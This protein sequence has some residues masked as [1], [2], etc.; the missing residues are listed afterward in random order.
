MPTTRSSSCTRSQN[1]S[2]SRSANDLRPFHVGTGATRMRKILAPRSWTY[3]SS[4]SGAV[5]AGGEADDRR[6]VDARRSRRRSSARASTRS[7]R[8]SPRT[9][10]SGSSARRSSSTLA[11]V[12]HSSVR[13]MPISFMSSRRGSGSKN[14]SMPGITTNFRWCSPPAPRVAESAAALGDVHP[15]RAG[16]RD[17]PERRVRDVVA[18]LVADRELRPAVD[19]DVLD[20]ALV[21]RRQELR[22]RVAGSRTCGCRRRTSGTA[23]RGA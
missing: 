13:S 15:G 10:A 11:S 4:S 17:L 5:D 19:L 18:D 20:D 9:A 7:A 1:G 14:A 16:R 12:G 21:L 3:S 6:G 8:G 23:A 22:Q 2:N